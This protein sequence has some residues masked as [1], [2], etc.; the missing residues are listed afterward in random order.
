MRCSRGPLT[1]GVH[2]TE[3][4]Q[5]CSRNEGRARAIGNLARRREQIENET[6]QQTDLRVESLD[7]WYFGRHRVHRS[8]LTKSQSFGFAVLILTGDDTGEDRADQP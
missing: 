5:V 2:K 4:L 1:L 3:V 8:S 7:R 6:V